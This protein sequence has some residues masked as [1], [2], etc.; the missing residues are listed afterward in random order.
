MATWHALAKLRLHTE[1]TISDLEGSSTRLCAL[2]RKFKK[3]V[4][5][6]YQTKDLP[7][8]VHARG[9]RAAKNAKK[10]AESGQST[11]ATSDG[12]PKVRE[13]NMNTYKIHAIPDYAASI[14]KYGTIDNTSSQMASSLF[15][16]YGIDS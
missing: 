13:F 16:S 8:E 3:E 4:C 12:R 9:R 2:L 6:K 7:A 5:S 14:R 15:F 10:A 1:T 11:S